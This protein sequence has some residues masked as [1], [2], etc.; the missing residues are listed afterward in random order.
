MGTRK[1]TA[2]KPSLHTRLR[3]LVGANLSRIENIGENRN[4]GFTCDKPADTLGLVGVYK[5]AGRRGVEILQSEMVVLS[6]EMAG[7]FQ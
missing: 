2:G 4:G 3:E 7:I 5:R 6:G 1:W